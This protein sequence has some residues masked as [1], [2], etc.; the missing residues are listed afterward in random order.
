MAYAEKRDGKLTGVWIGEVY[1]KGRT[2]RRRFKTKKDAEGYELYV[3]LTGDEPP[4]LENTQSTGA[5]TFAEVVVKAKA[6]GGPKGK[7]KAGRDGSLMQRLDFCVSVIGTHEV[8]Q[9]TRAVLGKIVER[10]EKKPA[11]TTRKRPLTP[12]TINR[13]LAAAHSVL[14][15]A[16][17]EG[18]MTERPPEAPYLDE[19]STRKERDI[20][21]IGQDEVILGLMRAAGH[22]VD[23]MCVEFLLE[24]GFRRGEL[25]FKLAPDQITV[26]QVPD[27]EGTVVPVGVV[28][29]HKGQT[30]NNR[31]RVAI[32]SADLAKNI[33]ALVATKSLPDGVQLLR[34]FKS[35]CEAAGYTGNL[36]LHSLRHTRNTR[37]RKAGITKEMRKQLLGHMSDEANAI[38]DHT[39]LEDHLMVAKKVEEYAGDRRKKA[40]IGEVVAFGKVS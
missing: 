15:F 19:A 16:H 21:H 6:K 29:L 24:T 11:S 38:Y 10:L 18:L 3:K 8:T 31:G 22:E 14:T 25:L 4:T 23:A 36:V 32:L 40:P 26:E 33:R 28:R 5:P 34:H 39:D 2:F 7:W 1:R 17:R 9:V 30:K 12:A 37:L 13:Y 27:E 20:L 35:A